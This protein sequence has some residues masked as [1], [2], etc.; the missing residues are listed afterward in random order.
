VPVRD[1]IFAPLPYAE[2]GYTKYT[3]LAHSLAC[4][5]FIVHT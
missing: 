2:T 1:R 5:L 4:D 3:V